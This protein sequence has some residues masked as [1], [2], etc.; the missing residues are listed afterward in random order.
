MTALDEYQ[1]LEAAGTFAPRSGGKRVEVILSLGKA[2][3]TITNLSDQAV[4]HWSL[5]AVQ[6]LNPGKAP[7]LYAPDP[8]TGERLETGDAEMIRAIEKVRSA[9]LKARPHPGRLRGRILLLLALSAIVAA[10]LWFPAAITR[11]T[12]SLVPEGA[13]AAI[14]EQLLQRITRV[15]GQPCDTPEGVAALSFMLERLGAAGPENAVVLP[16]GVRTAVHIPGGTVLLG[17]S[18]VEDHESPAV[19]AGY[20][21]AETERTVTEDPLLPLLRHAGLRATVTMAT[22]GRLPEWALDDYDAA[23]LRADPIPL[24]TGP[25]ADRFAAAGVS[26]KPYAYAVD[27][28]GEETL[29]LIEADQVPADPANPVI[30]DGRWVALQGICGG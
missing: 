30:P 11:K 25:T 5:A 23:L 24:P 4:W 12:A 7:A 14:G 8:D 17:R 29:P 20:L 6:R 10:A 18:V 9:V 21:L 22:T 15:T 19:A 2:T 13:R 1:R 16:D 27:I 26:L 28:T 3:L